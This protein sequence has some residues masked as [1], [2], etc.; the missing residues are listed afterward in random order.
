[1]NNIIIPMASIKINVKNIKIEAGKLIYCTDTLECY[2][3]VNST[4][5]IQ[6][7]TT[8]QINSET[9]RINLTEPDMNKIYIV[10]ET[11]K[12]YRFLNNLW[13]SVDSE[14]IVR[15][16]LFPAESLVPA[17]LQRKNRKQAPA[18][19]ASQVFLL[20]GSNVEQKVKEFVNDGKKIT[21]Q[22][23]TIHIPIEKDH[24]RII[25]IPF[26][27]ANYDIY[28]FPIILLKN[29]KIISTKDYAISEDQV[30]LSDKIETQI[31]DIM[32]FIF[33]Y[34]NMITNEELNAV[35]VNDVR[36]FVGENEPYDK[37]PTDVWFDIKEKAVKQWNGR[38]WTIIVKN[39]DNNFS[40]FKNTV[41]TNESTTFIPIGIDKYN[42]NTDILFVF[43][44]S[45]YIEQDMD[46][47]VSND[48]KNITIIHPDEIWNGDEEEITF[49]FIV[50]KNIN[51]EN[52]DIYKDID[53]K[54]FMK[55]S[56]DED[57]LSLPIQNKLH[58]LK[59][60]EEANEFTQI[61]TTNK[62]GKIDNEF[63]D[64]NIVYLNK[65]K[66]IDDEFININKKDYI[67]NTIIGEASGIVPLNALK[68]IDIKYIDVDQIVPNIE[69]LKN[70]VTID[71]ETNK[72]NINLIPST[73]EL[74]YENSDKLA[75]ALAVKKINDKI[76]TLNAEVIEKL[77]TVIE[78]RDLMLQ[79]AVEV[80]KLKGEKID[81]PSKTALNIESF[82]TK[83][84]S[85]I[86][87]GEYNAENKS[88]DLEGTDIKL[89]GYG[90]ISR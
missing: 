8:K 69:N 71:E 41:S 21:L 11:N 50:L 19:L 78:T 12:I 81:I 77:N 31:G 43:E 2:Y 89:N 49:N 27:V 85:T 70:V 34:C 44:N 37:I 25:N 54:L 88:V 61:V 60:I 58:L 73:S 79:L 90:F 65:N 42:K 29:D 9:D 66:K 13:V 16:L 52:S 10:K 48:S 3:D 18:T 55:G 57:K 33:S 67:L 15:D 45:T 84:N 26:P 36:F 24:Q 5:R 7:S 39:N 87:N 32:T 75:T 86:I 30:I 82:I 4:N 83:D 6:L 76:E 59:K 68:K 14:N 62:E 1:M 22:T 53:G 56:I 28:K 47:G 74:N 72:I 40:I 80:E 35:S 64:E 51:I 63:L 23:K 38:V 46:Y 17:T 20:D